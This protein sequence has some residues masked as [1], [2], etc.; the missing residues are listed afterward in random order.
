M[1]VLDQPKTS[2][3]QTVRSYGPKLRIWSGLILFTFATTHFINHGFGLVSVSAMQTGQDIRSVV[4]RS[5]PGTALL[6]SAATVHLVLG[7]STFLSARSW[8]LGF[9]GIVQLL[10]GLLIPI[11]LIRHV[12]STRVMNAMTGVRDDYYYALWALWPNLALNQAIL[13]SMVW[14]HGCIGLHHWLVLKPWYRRSTW[15]WYGLAVVIPFVGYAGFI[16]AGQVSKL[17]VSYMNP[18]TDEQF[19]SVMQVLRYSSYTYY[20][21]LIAALAIWLALIYVDR[22]RKKVAISYDNGPT[23]LAARG[24]SVLEV[25]QTNRIAHAS[26]CGGRARCSTCRVRVTEGLEN[27]PPASETEQKVLNRV[28]APPNVRLACQLRPET[29]ISVS[30]LLPA[31]VDAH[32]VNN[33]DKYLWGVEQDVTLL[34]CDLRGFT[35]MSEGRLSFDVVFLLNQFLSRMA[36]AIEDTGGYVDKFMGDGIMAIFG[37]DAP[38]KEG[39]LHAL[40]AARAMGGVL[41]ALNQS[42]R[43]EIQSPLS[44]GIGVHTGP[45]IMGRIGAAQ[46]T[47]AAARITALGETVNLASRLESMTKEMKVQ[48][49]LS[50]D[51]I[52]AAEVDPGENLTRETVEVRGL[53]QPITVF[54]SARATNLPSPE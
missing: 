43:E 46:K 19:A 24:L 31:S 16:A 47:E 18:F 37:M 4:T 22:Y 1:S 36:E 28:G 52:E 21:I 30:T 7:I 26:V 25:S 50:K 44:I 41:D 2:L 15:L 53:R 6:I 54:T 39:A 12:V 27:L 11:L 10:F 42:L 13:M 3:I 51:T 35:Q 34:F 14:I 17:Q 23:V 20:G 38:A 32:E 8:R 40:E 49:I 48:V 29:D 45:A 5:V 33:A 9:V